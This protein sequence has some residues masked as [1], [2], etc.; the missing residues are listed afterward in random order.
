V[1]KVKNKGSEH[2]ARPELCP[3]AKCLPNRLL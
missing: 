3:K 2:L 1:T